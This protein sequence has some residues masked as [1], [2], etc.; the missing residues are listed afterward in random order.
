MVVAAA[1][2]LCGLAICDKRDF[3]LFDPLHSHCASETDFPGESCADVYK[4]FV[5]VI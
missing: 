1:A 5:T 4:R 2:I 3:P